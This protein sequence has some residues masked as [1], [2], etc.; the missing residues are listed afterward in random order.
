MLEST[1]RIGFIPDMNLEQNF[2]IAAVEAIYEVNKASHGLLEKGIEV[3]SCSPEGRYAMRNLIT[4]Q[5]FEQLIGNFTAA[6]DSIWSKDRDC[7]D[8]YVDNV[9]QFII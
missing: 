3:I 8:N 1:D 7:H 2:G 9:L 4:I 5:N 6:I